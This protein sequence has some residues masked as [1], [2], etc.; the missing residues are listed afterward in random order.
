MKK[1]I[2]AVVLILILAGAGTPLLSGIMME[3]TLKQTFSD[4]NHVYQDRGLDFSCEISE[5]DR[6]FLSSQIV[7]KIKLGAFKTFYGVDEI[8]FVD[9]AEHGFTRVV[10]HTSLEKN[11]WFMD[12]LDQQLNGKN[13]L[14]ISTAFNY[15]GQFFTTITLDGFSLKKDHKVLEFMPGNIV[16]R[17]DKDL[18]DFSMQGTLEGLSASDEFTVNQVSIDSKMEKLSNYIW[19][20]NMALSAQKI[21]AGKGSD[22]VALSNVTCDYSM[23]LDKA[24]NA[25]SFKLRYGTDGIIAGQN[26][27]EDASFQ[28]GI[29]HID[30]VG[31]EAFMKL[32][33]ELTSKAIG[34]FSAAS[35]QDP[36]KTKK[37]LEKQFASL[38]LQMA[39]AYEKLM[40]QGLEIQISDLEAK[41]PQGQIRGDFSLSLKKDMTM[42]Q[43]VPL[44]MQPTLAL[45]I[46]SLKSN[47]SLPYKLV[48]ANP[49]LLNP[50]YPGMRTGLFVKKG[51][52]MVH[53]AETR[54]GKLF[55][56][57]E[58]L[59]L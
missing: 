39:G 54:N 25:L 3:R 14:D 31:F 15:S 12:F 10:S 1:T 58:E 34:D 5:Y 2:L 30:F 7:W 41:L 21:Q 20:G 16:T 48:G 26:E 56:N 53:N 36:E 57:G 11:K 17:I 22:R 42:V 37:N 6:D 43:F 33:A 59:T 46:F 18:K 44:M 19:G 23:D 8:V 38:G 40:K 27:I 9:R 24:E 51:D 45:D 32:Y 4:I 49:K 13:P 55:L 50:M 52:D 28:I 35:A 29:N 47:L